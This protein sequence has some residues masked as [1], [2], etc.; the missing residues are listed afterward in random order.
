LECR[1]ERNTL[2]IMEVT[3]HLE[4]R[5]VDLARRLTGIHDVHKLLPFVLQRFSQLEAGIQLARAG[6]TDPTFEVPPRRRPDDP[7]D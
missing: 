7:I 2:M 6:G 4:E 5:D 1:R 3:I